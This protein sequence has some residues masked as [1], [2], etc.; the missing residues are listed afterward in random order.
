MEGVIK[1]L[2]SRRLEVGN[3]TNDNSIGIWIKSHLQRKQ[4]TEGNR[5]KEGGEDHSSFHNLFHFDIKIVCNLHLPLPRKRQMSV[6]RG[7]THV[8][9]EMLMT[10]TAHRTQDK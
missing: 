10:M 1:A 6:A 2:K 3:V 7:R 9:N 5:E 8:A 4:S